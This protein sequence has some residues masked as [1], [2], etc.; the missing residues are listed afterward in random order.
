MFLKIFLFFQ[1]W[2]RFLSF[3]QFVKCR[4]MCL[5]L[6]CIQLS[7]KKS[8]E[9]SSSCVRV[10]IKRPSR[11]FCCPNATG[12][13]GR[14]FQSIRSYLKSTK[15]CDAWAEV[16]L[17]GDVVKIFQIDCYC[18]PIWRICQWIQ[19]QSVETLSVVLTTHIFYQIFHQELDPPRAVV[20]QTRAALK[21]TLDKITQ[22]DENND[23]ATVGI[24][25][26]IIVLYLLK[27]V[28]YI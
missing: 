28:T 15:K 23:E 11:R 3:A 26:I 14:N 13:F 24:D 25:I 22:T 19:T 16:L 27:Q 5:K 10:F 9:T 17:C 2:L 18:F 7:S 1:T 6:N 12:N 21:V 8:Q 4:W 20:L